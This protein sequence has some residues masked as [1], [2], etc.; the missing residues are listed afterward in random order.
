MNRTTE[1]RI[2]E[3][4][5]HHPEG[6]AIAQAKEFGVDLYSILEN[7][8]LSPAERW[9]RASEKTDFVRRIRGESEKAGS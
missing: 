9:R 1:E 3:L 2:R 8:K 5:E 6:S 4:S 7:L